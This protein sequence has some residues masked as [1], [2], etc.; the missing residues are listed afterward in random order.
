MVSPGA[1]MYGLHFGEDIS[2]LASQPCIVSLPAGPFWATIYGLH[3]G[4]FSAC[5]ARL[6]GTLHWREAGRNLRFPISGSRRR[7]QVK[8]QNDMTGTKQESP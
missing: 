2:L 5:G 3:F 8:L 1:I 6:V 7:N 4:D